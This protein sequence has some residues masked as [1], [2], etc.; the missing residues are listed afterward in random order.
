MTQNAFF[1]VFLLSERQLINI[2]LDCY[3]IQTTQAIDLGK[4][5][6]FFGY[7]QGIKNKIKIRRL[8]FLLEMKQ[9]FLKR[10]KF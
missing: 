2:D 1:C 9:I 3:N 8:C 7:F 6:L 4:I 5:W 10:L